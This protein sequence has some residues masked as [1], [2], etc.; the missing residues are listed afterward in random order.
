VSTTS[1]RAGKLA[2]AWRVNVADPSV[3]P[4]RSLTTQYQESDQ[5][6]V[7]RLLAEGTEITENNPAGAYQMLLSTYKLYAVPRF[8]IDLGFNSKTQDRIAVAIIE[9]SKA[10][11]FI[12]QG[13]IEDAVRALKGRWASLPGGHDPRHEQRN[14]FNYVFTNSDV[15][16]SFETYMNELLGK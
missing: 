13:K 2:P 14:G 3:Y 8:G 1:N 12:R 6:F 10:L 7:E 15:T 9:E 4:Q 11:G 16:A 5:D